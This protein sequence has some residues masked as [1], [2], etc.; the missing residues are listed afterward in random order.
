MKSYLKFFSTIRILLLS[1]FLLFTNAS[2]QIFKAKSNMVTIKEASFYKTFGGQ[3]RSRSIN[4]ELRTEES[5]ASLDA[6]YWLEVDG[7]K[8]DLK[9]HQDGDISQLLGYYTENRPSREVDF[10]K[11]G[12]F[13]KVPFTEVVLKIKKPEETVDVI[14]NKLTNKPTKYYP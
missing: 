10:D 9:V 7:F 3:G 4:F 11:H 13:D 8:V 5:L 14:V 2:C 6:L 12:L 1:I